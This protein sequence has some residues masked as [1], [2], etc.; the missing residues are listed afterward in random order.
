MA[1]KTRPRDL[2]ASRKLGLTV[3]GLRSGNHKNEREGSHEAKSRSGT[4][5]GASGDRRI[6]TVVMAVAQNGERRRAVR[7][8]VGHPEEEIAGQVLRRE[9]TREHD[10]RTDRAAAE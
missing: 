5:D 3:Q 8:Q 1:E 7:V 4:E 10:G 9:D 6:S 2:G